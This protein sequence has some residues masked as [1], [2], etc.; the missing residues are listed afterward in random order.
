VDIFLQIMAAVLL[1]L[2]FY[3]LRVYLGLGRI[4]FMELYDIIRMYDMGTGSIWQAVPMCEH[5]KLHAQALDLRARVLERL[6]AL[7]H[8][9][10]ELADLPTRVFPSRVRRTLLF[11]GTCACSVSARVSSSVASRPWRCGACS[12]S[13]SL[14]IATALA[15]RRA[16]VPRHAG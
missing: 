1:F 7:A 16:A 9:V 12:R 5:C 13:A 8:R 10:L 11:A 6:V 2:G 4:V 3:L 15:A 14:T